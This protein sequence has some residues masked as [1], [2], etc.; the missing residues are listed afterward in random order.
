[1]TKQR[2]NTFWIILLLILLLG[3]IFAK[4]I[5]KSMGEYLIV[6]DDLKKADL[7]TSVS[8]PDYRALYA[9]RLCKEN[10]ASR[11]FYTGGYNEF[12]ERYAAAWSQYLATTIGVPP[13]E[14][15]IDESTV[16]S[17]YEEAE[18]VKAYVDAHPGKI[19]TIIVV[20]DPYHT[21]RA[22]WAYEKVL[23]S[24]ITVLMAPV[25]FSD[26]GYSSSWWRDAYS[27]EMVLKEYLK[28]GFYLLRYQWTSGL[29]QDLLAKFDRF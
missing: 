11:L 20:T 18:R 3:V 16:I 25:P 14:I 9:A 1:M 6:S 7:I 2:R 12:D 19:D 21:R 13:E 4:P 26:T 17:T 28:Y 27:R 23:G 8:G 15:S 5:L 22:K 24:E 29:L 10:M